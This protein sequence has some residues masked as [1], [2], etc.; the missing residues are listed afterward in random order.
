MKN[1]LKV[2]RIISV[3][4]LALSFLGC[5]DDN[6]VLPKVTAGFTYTVNIDTGTVTF[7]NISDNANTYKWDF[8]DGTSSTFINPSKTY[9]NGT[10]TIVLE[11]INVSGA[12]DTFQDEIT[13]L[14]P[15]IATVPISFDGENTKYDPEVFGGA[16]FMVVD[17]PDPSG[18]NASVS[19]VG[20]IT[21]SGAA[22]EGFYFDLGMPLDLSTLKTV[23]ALFWSDAP[24]SVLLKLE[25]GTGADIETTANHGGTGWEEIYFTFDSS[26]SYSRFTMFVDGPGTTSGKFYIDDISQIATSD[27]PCPQTLLELPIDFDCN[28]IDYATKIVGNVS[29]EVLD[30]PELSGINAEESK[31]GK[32]VNVGENW[33]NAFFNL[34]TAIDF[35]VNNAVRFKLFSNQALPIKLKFEDGTEDPVESDVNHTGSGWEELTFN[36]TSTAS[37]NDMILFVDGPGTA[38]GTFYIDDIEQ[39]AGISCDPETAQSLAAA[40]LNISFM[41]DPSSS[42]IEDGANF[43]WIDNPD[44]NN[45]TNSSCKV[46]QI[47]KLGNNPWDNTQID[48]DAKLDFNANDGLKIK[49]W[50]G[51]SNT[52]VRIKLEE[53]GNPSNNVEKF[54]TTSITSAWEELTFPF[55]STDSGKYDKIVMFFD[56]NANNMDTYY[57]DDLMLYGSGSG[58]GGGGGTGEDVILNFENNLAGVTTGEFETGGALIANPFSGGINTSPNVYE[59]TYT[60]GNQWWGGVGFVF[61]SGLDQT[62]TVYKAK[63]YSTVAPSNVLFQVEVDGTN[64]PVGNVQTITTANQW[65]ELTFTLANIPSGVNRILIRPDVG[66]QN[67]TKPNTGSLY[68]DDITKV[69]DTGGSGGGGSG[70]GGGG[71]G[72]NLAANGDFETGDDT[73]WLLFQNGGTAVIDNSLSNGGSWSG[74]IETNGP[75]NPAFKQEA[76]GAGTVAAGNTVTVT[77]D[78]IGSTA[79]EGGVFNVLLFGEGAGGASFTHVFNPAPILSGSW[80]TFSGSFTIPGGTDVSGGISFLIETVCGGATGCSVSANIDNVSVTLN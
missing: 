1:I 19:K 79:G 38:A 46:G 70:G 39:V 17:N 75:S 12:K 13:I 56:L 20:E 11:A 80:T 32:I 30:N 9:E 5:E 42:F 64:A 7:I 49:V 74:K 4:I 16:S 14:I 69:T 28:S 63:F 2:F 23:K 78:H 43:D 3:F 8:G 31:V 58:T 65:V 61:N 76:I 71:T 67:G 10:Y 40:T 55:E 27:I 15:E 62:T 41:S 29:F 77:F 47:T 45:D 6:V 72:D 18:A 34:D 54:L 68:I 50:S 59:A 26:S 37:Y 24:I 52:E 22:F 66:D 53:I 73:G 57:F 25:N 51:R 21:N 44:F 48:L 36:F 35:S 33:E 60:N